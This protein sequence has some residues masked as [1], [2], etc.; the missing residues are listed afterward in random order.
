MNLFF[1]CGYSRKNE[2]TPWESQVLNTLEELGFK[3]IKVSFP[4]Q[5]NEPRM[6][7]RRMAQSFSNGTYILRMSHHLSCLKDGY[8][9]DR[10]DCTD[11]CVYFAWRIEKL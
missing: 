5:R 2:K 7:G 6:N 11:K 10:W 9:Y 8:V 3:A 4:A 1:E